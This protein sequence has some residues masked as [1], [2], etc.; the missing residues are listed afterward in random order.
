MRELSLHTVTL[1][2]CKEA[3]ISLIKIKK[4]FRL[5]PRQNL[6]LYQVYAIHKRHLKQIKVKNK[7]LGNAYQANANKKKAE[8]MILAKQGRIQGRKHKQDKEIHFIILMTNSQGS[9]DSYE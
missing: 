3:F 5:D 9:Y 2:K 8:F 7:R 6:M 4:V 1:R